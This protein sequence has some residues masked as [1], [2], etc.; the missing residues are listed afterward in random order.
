MQCGQLIEYQQVIIR[1]VPQEKSLQQS[2]NKPNA[3]CIN[4]LVNL[5][6][7]G[8]TNI[9]STESFASQKAVLI[10]DADMTHEEYVV[11]H[12]LLSAVGLS[13]HQLWDVDCHEV[14][15]RSS[16][17]K[18]NDKVALKQTRTSILCIFR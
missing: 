7:S 1:S 10:T 17:M 15:D 16:A 9:P 8:V 6:W 11:W 4:N 12:S 13:R 5:R 3:D 14:S 18:H 2:A